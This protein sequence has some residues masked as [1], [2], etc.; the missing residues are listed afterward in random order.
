M[1]PGQRTD[2]EIYLDNNATTAPLPEV[3]HE[4]A[5]CY[6]MG[7]LNPSSVH[8]AG[9]RARRRLQEAREQTA[10]ALG[11]LPT[12]VLFT[13]GATE[14][15]HLVLRGLLAGSMK[16]FQLVT[17]AVEHS[18]ILEAARRLE[19]WG[20]S[21]RILPVDRHGLID[22]EE[23]EGAIDPQRTLVSVQ[24]ANNETGV[25][26]PLQSIAELCQARGAVLHSDA[27]QAVGKLP[28]D[29]SRI[30]V[31]FLSLSGH[32]LHGPVGS[33]VLFRRDPAAL[34]PV[35][36]G[37]G[38]ESGIRPGTENLP[39]V[40][41]LAVALEHRSERLHRIM[42]DLGALRHRFET[43]LKEAGMVE[44]INGADAPRIPNTSSITFKGVDG[45]AL[46]LR[47]DQEGVQCSQSSACT[48]R[49]PEPSYVLRAMGLS[50]DEAFR[51]V[52]FSFSEFN[53]KDEV[54]RAL[55]TLNRLHSTLTRFHVPSPTVMT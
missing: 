14:A 50:E 13:S 27:V 26:Q 23:L 39:A 38:Q 20:V 24:W 37:G 52:R 35:L 21:V 54:D 29:L 10:A 1:S 22:L 51:S 42:A 30:P 33:G 19:D 31:D 55:D 3:V 40:V 34:T 8:Q 12:Q 49:K 32:K 46:L 5:A 47:L 53:T 6:R 45:E 43:G 18:S 9:A 16:G 25:L 28:M 48:N 2:P 41:G 36:P 7:P 11:A 4:M 44:A 17:T 15:N